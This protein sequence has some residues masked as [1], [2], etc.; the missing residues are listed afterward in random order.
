[1]LDKVKTALRVSSNTFDSEIQDLINAALAD[2]RITG[3]NIPNQGGSSVLDDPLLIR[4]VIYYC[5]ANYG[6]NEDSEKFQ[7]T[8]EQLRDKLSLAGEYHVQ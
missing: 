2:L 4:A 5:K 6:Y 3:V 1:M 8:Y 7:R